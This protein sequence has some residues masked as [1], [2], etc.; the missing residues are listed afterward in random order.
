MKKALVG[1][2]ALTGVFY[3]FCLY[4]VYSY[5]K[6]SFDTKSDVAIVLGGWFR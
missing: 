5:S 3:A 2:L 6:V 1:L 4:S